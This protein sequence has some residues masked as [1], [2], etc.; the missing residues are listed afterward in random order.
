MWTCFNQRRHREYFPSSKFRTTKQNWRFNKV[1]KKI[2]LT[3]KHFSSIASRAFF[4]CYKTRKMF[5]FS[6]LLSCC[7]CLPIHTSE[8]KLGNNKFICFYYF[9]VRERVDSYKNVPH[10]AHI[11]STSS[12]CTRQW[13]ENGNVKLRH[14]SL[15]KS[16]RVGLKLAVNWRKW[17]I[18]NFHFSLFIHRWV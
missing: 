15:E 16:S 18:R 6:Y 5:L 14:R 10:S 13:G 3:Q 12:T 1:L 7:R 11:Y 9:R 17:K 2:Q 4:C 8:I